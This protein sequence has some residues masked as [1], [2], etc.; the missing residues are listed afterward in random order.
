M[1]SC[2]QKFIDTVRNKN[3]SKERKPFDAYRKNQLPYSH[4]GR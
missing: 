1:Q 3:N 4:E 2:N